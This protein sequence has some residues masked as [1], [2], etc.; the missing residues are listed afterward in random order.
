MNIFVLNANKKPIEKIIM[1][2]L[3]SP[4][5]KRLVSFAKYRITKKSHIKLNNFR[6]R[7]DMRAFNAKMLIIVPNSAREESLLKRLASKYRL[8][9]GSSGKAIGTH[10]VASVKR[11]IVIKKMILLSRFL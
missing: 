11:I 10:N 8:E 2:A 7:Q 5:Q 6:S 1:E 9:K 4:Q 3:K